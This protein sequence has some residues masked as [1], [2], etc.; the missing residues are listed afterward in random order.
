M[1]LAQGSLHVGLVLVKRFLLGGLD[2][3]AAFLLGA[4]VHVLAPR[5]DT[6]VARTL[7]LLFELALLLGLVLHLLVLLLGTLSLLLELQGGR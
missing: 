6:G 1:L 5:A 7:P 3:A 4:L 2:V